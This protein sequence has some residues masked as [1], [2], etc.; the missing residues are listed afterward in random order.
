M[1]DSGDERQRVFSVLAV[2]VDRWSVCLNQ[3]HTF[4]RKL[5]AAESIF[6][7]V[8][9]HATEFVAGRGRI[10]A[11]A[12][13]KGARCRIFKEAL[14]E[15]AG[16]PGVHLFNAAGPKNEDSRLFERMLNRINRTMQ[17]W[18]SKCILVSDQGK[19]YSKLMRKMRVHNPIPS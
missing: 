8:E 3:F 1:D 6:V 14:A 11:I 12:I 17:A 13:P 16:L 5:K 18:D 15:I 10:S 7:R 2:P 9:F 4:R 19:D